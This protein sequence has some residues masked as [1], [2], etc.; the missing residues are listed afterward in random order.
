MRPFFVVISAV[1]LRVCPCYCISTRGDGE[2]KRNISAIRVRE[3]LRN[4]GGVD[5][6]L[7]EE[8]GKR[9]SFFQRSRVLSVEKKYIVIRVE[10]WGVVRGFAIPTA[11]NL[12]HCFVRLDRKQRSHGVR[13]AVAQS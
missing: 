1:V 10:A 11:L 9:L 4:K 12:E 2:I 6:A 5:R 8:N 7:H 3:T 13:D